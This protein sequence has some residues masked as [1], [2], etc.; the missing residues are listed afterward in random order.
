MYN[1]YI[2]DPNGRYEIRA[3][4]EPPCQEPKDPVKE[5]M[6]NCAQRTD[7]KSFENGMDLGDLLLLCII[8]LIC[9]D[10]NDDL[11]SVL[12]TAAAFLFMQ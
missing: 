6:P 9:L 11:Q 10:Q 5:A 8:L 3:M 7:Y 4:Q 12:I 2:P 1:R